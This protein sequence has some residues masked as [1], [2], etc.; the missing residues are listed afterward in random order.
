MLFS[1]TTLRYWHNLPTICITIYCWNTK[2]P[3]TSMTC[4]YNLA[5]ALWLKHEK[6]SLLFCNLNKVVPMA[7]HA[8]RY[9]QLTN[10]LI[11]F[12]FGS[13]FVVE[14]KLS[15]KS[16]VYFQFIYCFCYCVV[17]LILSEVVKRYSCLQIITLLYILG[18]NYTIRCF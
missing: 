14:D 13:W 15:N 8:Y 6:M 9:I 18:K 11:C 17:V 12:I 10:H 4:D 2:T 1:M 5:I 3:Y 16:Y 7:W